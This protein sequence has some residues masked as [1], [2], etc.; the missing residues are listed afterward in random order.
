MVAVIKQ[1]LE[2]TAAVEEKARQLAALEEDGQ[3][4]ETYFA[5][6][7][8][9]RQLWQYVHHLMTGAGWGERKKQQE[10]ASTGRFELLQA[11][12]A[13]EWKKAK[14][15]RQVSQRLSGAVRQAADGVLQQALRYSKEF[16]AMAQDELVRQTVD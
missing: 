15:C 16:F 3:T 7:Q 6:V 9:Q 13:D 11:L 2:T 10:A 8:R 5:E 1:L 12:T 14:L 4:W